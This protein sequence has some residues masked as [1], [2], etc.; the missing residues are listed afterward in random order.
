MA[1]TYVSG[2]GNA[3]RTAITNASSGDELIVADGTYTS[4]SPI[5]G[6]SKKLTVRSENGPSN[7]ILN[8]QILFSYNSSLVPNGVYSGPERWNSYYTSYF[9]GFT[10]EGNGAAGSQGDHQLFRGMKCKNCIFQGW[11]PT[12]G[13]INR[14]VFINCI[15]R[16]SK[17][18]TD[19]LCGYSYLYNCL[20]INNSYSGGG[21]TL[22]Y[23]S[24]VVNSLFIENLNAN[25]TNA[26]GFNGSYFR[27]KNKIGRASALWD[28]Q[29]N[30]PK[31]DATGIWGAGNNAYL[32][33]N[34]DL[35][36]DVWLDPPS[37]GCYEFSLMR[38]YDTV[39][40]EKFQ[41]V[42]NDLRMMQR[43]LENKVI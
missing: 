2:G 3:L 18:Q 36:G 23:S 6:G 21:S 16:N 10:F 8:S 4:G 31:Q 22:A 26:A 25:G 5:N 38:K 1:V 33:S 40:A 11:K 29:L 15:I 42:D 35:N 7:C 28:S 20:F 17:V 34:C 13:I 39:L 24:Q 12:Y 9:E 27:A 32:Q 43:T 19:R 14:G 41:R 37:I 30:R